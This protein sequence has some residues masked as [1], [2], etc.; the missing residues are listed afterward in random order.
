MKAL[1]FQRPP[2][3]NMVSQIYPA[4]KTWLM[5]PYSKRGMNRAEMIA[6]YRI[7]RGRR[8][9]ENDFGILSSRMKNEKMPFC[10]TLTR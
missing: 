6:N 5:K 9:M 1:D 8:V 4:L 2:P 7:S 10:C 3:L